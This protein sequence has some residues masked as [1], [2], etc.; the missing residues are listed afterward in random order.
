MLFRNT[1]FHLNCVGVV[2]Q[3]DAFIIMPK[4]LKTCKKKKGLKKEA[5][6]PPE[7]SH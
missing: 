1:V 6:H 7:S 2:F 3:K 4:S 5:E